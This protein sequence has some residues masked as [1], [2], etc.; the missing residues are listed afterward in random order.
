MIPG[1]PEMTDQR[2]IPF[3]IT[4][5]GECRFYLFTE[6]C[7]FFR[8]R[9]EGPL[10]QDTPG[11]FATR[12]RDEQAPAAVIAADV[13]AGQMDGAPCLSFC[14][15]PEERACIQ[16]IR[17]TARVFIGGIF[18]RI[19]PDFLNITGIGS[20]RR[21]RCSRHDLLLSHGQDSCC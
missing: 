6:V 19:D 16:Q 15:K 17:N 7:E 12:I 1:C 20:C 18:V 10:I 3:L 4:E 8:I 14:I 21:Q 13:R 2:I 11:P 5:S 9:K